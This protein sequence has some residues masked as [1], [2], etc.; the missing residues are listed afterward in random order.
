[1]ALTDVARND[2]SPGDT[3]SQDAKPKTSGTG[4]K[5]RLS[6]FQRIVLA[7]LIG[8]SV[9]VFL[10]ELA[11]PLRTVGDVYVGLLQM[12][13]L[14]FIICSVIGNIGRLTLDQSKRLA[15]T[16]FAVFFVL[17]GVGFAVLFLMAKTL[18]VVPAG[19]FFSTSLIE[20][21]REFDFI[22]I[23]V[24]SNPFRSL[25][26]N[27]VP[28]VVLFC[29]LIGFALMQ[30]PNK[31]ATLAVFDTL[32][33]TLGRVSNYVTRLS[34]LGVFAI[35]AS[36]AGTITLEEF[37][38]L[39]AY[40]LIF[41]GAVLLLVIVILP[42]IV[43]AVTPFRYV[44][45]IAT[46]ANVL[47]TALAI[48]SV[49]AVIPLLVE[50]QKNLMA[51]LP[52]RGVTTD[53]HKLEN[54]A[55]FIIP[56]A[57][58]FPHLGKVVTLIFVPF[59]A[60][61]YGRPMELMEYSTVFSAGLFLSFGKVTVTIPFLLDLHEI[62]ADIFRLFLMSSVI[63]GPL[64][65]LLGAAH[66]LAFTTLTICAMT[67]LL[68]LKRLNFAG[69]IVVGVGI[70]LLVFAGTKLTLTRVFSDLFSRD[71]VVATM[72]LLEDP[73]AFEI[74]PVSEPNPDPLLPGES[75]IER[76]DRRGKLRV[77]FDPDNL[78]FSYYN[79]RGELVGHDI[80]LAHRLA[81]DLR[82]ELE[83]V[84]SNA[85]TLSEQIRQDH[86][87]IAA[88]GI[89]I[90]LHAYEGA[91]Y[92]L[93][94]SAV[95]LAFVVADHE[96]GRYSTIAELGTGKG[97]VLGVKKGSYFG[98]FI[99]S[100]LPDARMV[101]LWSESQF[102]EGPPERMDALV[103]TAEGGSAWTL[104]H[105]NFAVIDPRDDETSAP[106]AFLLTRPDTQLALDMETW[107]RL[108][109]HDGTLEKLYNYWILGRGTERTGAR[110]SVVRNVLN[111]VE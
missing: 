47:I 4:G 59:A 9:G 37:G 86:F 55:E 25:A 14:P 5:P 103:T 1:M 90:N 64:S 41:G 108:K 61:F 6:P 50:S 83:L 67:G 94:Y 21:P 65:D 96:R 85:L 2:R 30:S 79:A 71:N 53:H 51:R 74:V 39:Q 101:E 22:R 70:S 57:Y 34:P 8:I 76:I 98:R 42:L 68:H 20:P 95:N 105:P 43:A 72:N 88:S 16:S 87:D 78:P 60:W 109:Q 73:I 19:S 31:S 15:I 111:W 18:P 33:D 35:A 44:D 82:A 26:E 104:I 13:V 69:P 93:P 45:I 49:F 12:T 36:S 11:A 10:G 7:L 100:A 17:W 32:N 89:E 28:G 92:S 58:P 66:L 48:G 97:L 106:I 54:S 80:D 81:S 23:F 62:P 99:Q 3:P 40:F 77:G 46:Q 84:P 91:V 24:P 56:L 63:A 75:L 38:R 102:F 29:I 27:L 107:I 110:W 52:D